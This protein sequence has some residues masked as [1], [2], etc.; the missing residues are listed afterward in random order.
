MNIAAAFTS[1]WLD[2][3]MPALLAHIEKPG[4]V[5]AARHKI[6]RAIARDV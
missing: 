2:R 5:Q 3:V 1:R 6:T 4:N